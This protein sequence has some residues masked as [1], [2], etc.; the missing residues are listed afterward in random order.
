MRDDRVPVAIRMAILGASE[1]TIHRRARP[2]AP[3]ARSPRARALDAVACQR[4]RSVVR[5]T[6]GLVGAKG[7]SKRFGIPRRACAAI[8][9][10]E[11]CVLELERKARCQTVSI[12][13]PGI[14]RGFDAMHVT[15][16]DRKAYWLVA[17]D[18]AIP[19][20]TSI[21]AV[22]VYDSKHVVTALRADFESNGAP[23]VIRLDRIACQRT[24]EVAALLAHYR[25]LALH[26]PPR[27]PGY[28]GQLE[29]QNRE[30]RAWLRRHGLPDW[31]ELEDV[32]EA[33]RRS[34]NA[35]WPRPTLNW[36][37][38]QEVWQRRVSVAIDRHELYE[39]VESDA[40]ELVT[41]GLEPLRA[42]RFAIES[43]LIARGLLT[44]NS[45][46]WC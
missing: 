7:L 41:Y 15:C 2:T 3:V 8:K 29:R 38:A 4:V 26:G 30:H 34:L 9:Q 12:L 21:T 10:R 28:Y 42:R 31:T 44:I 5:D 40:S 36:C 13:A 1:S 18:G 37:T 33:M 35:L 32:A 11:L 45:G 20:R 39:S 17:A 23:L 25:V 24:P 14:V 22:P 46:G 27:H 43:A 19:Y 16:I 6:R